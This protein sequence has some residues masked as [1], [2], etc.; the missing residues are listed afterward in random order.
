MYRQVDES[1]TKGAKFDAKRGCG[2]SDP[3]TGEQG[4]GSGVP[5][6]GTESLT[7][8]AR[9]TPEREDPNLTMSSRECG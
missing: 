8:S 9:R 3:S 6:N 2:I 1:Y 4:I 5:D 7:L